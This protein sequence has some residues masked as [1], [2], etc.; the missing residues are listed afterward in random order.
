MIASCHNIDHVQAGGA[1]LYNHRTVAIDNQHM[2]VP[3]ARFEGRYVRIHLII[4]NLREASRVQSTMRPTS[5]LRVL[6]RDG[7]ICRASC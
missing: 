2:W 7:D 4:S 1:T 6:R 3:A 5:E